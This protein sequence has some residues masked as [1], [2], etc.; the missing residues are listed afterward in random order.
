MSVVYYRRRWID[1]EEPAM[2]TLP[3]TAAKAGVPRGT[4]VIV[5]ASRFDLR[6]WRDVLPFLL[7]AFRIRRQMLN[8][9]GA[10][11]V[12]LIARPTQRTFY[13]LSA[14]QDRDALD[15]AV[16]R[17][18]HVE[19]MTRFGPRMAGSRFASWTAP[20]ST[21]VPPTWAEAYDRLRHEEG[22]HG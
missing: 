18:P 14:W 19:T 3:W 8:S 16:G 20:A 12:S 13:T 21:G 7:A 1:D 6:S 2:P 11:G 10:V 4:D 5:M 15:A 17:R 9:T 22:L